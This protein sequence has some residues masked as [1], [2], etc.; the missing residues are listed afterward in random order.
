MR[1]LLSL[2]LAMFL[3]GCEKDPVEQVSPD[4]VA[5]SVTSAE[6]D[7][8]VVV[9]GHNA[10]SWDVYGALATQAGD[11]NVFF[12]PFSLTSALGMTMAGAN[13][14][15]EGEMRSVLHVE[16]DEA[17]WHGAL[18]ALTRDLNGDF[19]RG[20]TLYVANQLFGQT[21]YPWEEPFLG[22]CEADYGA[23]LQE[24]DFIS[25]PEGG[26][27]LVNDWVEDHTEGR[28][29]DLL[30]PGSVT[31]G[32]R[33][34]LANAIYFLADWKTAFDPED[35]SDGYFTRLD[36][37]QVT[38]P[39]MH[40]SLEDVEEHGIESGWADGVQLLRLP[41]QDDEVSMVLVIPQE[42]DGLPDVE[43]GLDQ[44]QFD[45]WLAALGPSEA[46]IA[47]PRLEMKYEKELSS[48]LSSLGMPVAFTDGADFSGIAIPP[49]DGVLKITG[50]FH[51]AFVS[52]DEAGTEAA[53]ATGVVVGNDS[54]PEPIF[55]D[56]PFLFVVQDDLTGAILF[57]GRVTDPS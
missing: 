41:Y 1:S 47:M 33:L 17:A 50:V 44:A 6:G 9:R 32:T 2:S 11:E 7:T 39:M 45:T 53:A 27:A 22:I 13:G 21:D 42:G 54:A 38:V 31:D 48:T 49:E 35:T 5:R 56:R 37:T 55:A 36:G 14:G 19:D 3:I 10:F 24:W 40:M 46:N 25:D 26:R 29:V 4:R 18:G 15:T 52:V 23:P 12:S 43:A 57:V 20:Y 16:G 8:G 51:Q 28:I 34:V 30:P